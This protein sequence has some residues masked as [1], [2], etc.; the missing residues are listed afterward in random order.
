MDSHQLRLAFGAQF[1]PAILEIADQF[2]LLGVYR[3]DWL[4]SSQTP[5]HLPVQVLK[6]SVTVRMLGPLVRFPVGL[7]AIAQLMQQVGDD[8]MADLMLHPLQLFAQLA[9]ALAGP[10]Q[11]RLRVTAGGGFQ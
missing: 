1:T 11:R 2:L 8:L 7:Q 4:V 3:D 10:S 9:H 6:L 5:F